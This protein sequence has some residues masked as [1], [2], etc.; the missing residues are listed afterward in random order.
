M[1]LYFF[2][3]ADERNAKI[4]LSR[5]LDENAYRGAKEPYI[6]YYP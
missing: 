1:S 4:I 5:G 2:F 3:Q 6:F